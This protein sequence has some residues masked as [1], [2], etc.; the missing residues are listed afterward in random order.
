MNRSTPSLPVH[1]QIPNSCPL[2]RSCHPTISSSV[3][4]FSSC[5]QSFPASGSFPMSQLFTSG[6]Q[7]IGAS[8][9]A[10]VLPMNIQGWFP[11]G[12]TGLI[13]PWF[14]RKTHLALSRAEGKSFPSPTVT[15]CICPVGWITHGS[16]TCGSICVCS[17]VMGSCWQSS[18][19]FLCLNASFTPGWKL[20]VNDCVAAATFWGRLLKPA[21][22]QPQIS[23]R[24]FRVSQKG[25]WQCLGW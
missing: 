15:H 25:P 20:H 11:L 7:S 23:Q 17:G 24:L 13:T 12:W 18:A 1:H 19:W 4:P 16:V 21:S 2:S 22:H 10:S 9:S 6:G 3:I 5:P 8:A 14:Q